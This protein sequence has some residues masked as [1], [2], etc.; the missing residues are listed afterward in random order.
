MQKLI[1]HRTLTLF[2]TIAC[3]AFAEP[4]SFRAEVAPLLVKNCLACHGPQKAEGAYR[5]DSFDRLMQ[6]GDSGEPG[7]I[8]K[9]VDS[10][11]AFRRITS[12]DVDERMPLEADPLASGQIALVRRWIEEGA[13]YDA[14]DPTLPLVKIIPPPVHPNAPSEYPATMPV[15]A[16]AFSPDGNELFVGGYYELTVWNPEDGR[17]IRRIGNIGQRTY[18]LAFSP[19]GNSL[20]VACGAPGGLGEL[21]MINP[22]DGQLQAVVASTTDVVFDAAFDPGGGR[23]AIA[24]ADGVLRVFDVV[25]REPLLEISSHSDWVTAVAW[26]LH[27]DRLATASR[28]K[29]AKVFDAKTGELIVTYNGHSG[30]VAGVAFHPDGKQV[31]TSAADKRI[32]LWK[33][34][35]GKK[36]ADVG[37]FGGELYKLTASSDFLFAVSDDKTARQYDRN[38]PKELRKYSGHSESVLSSAYHNA[39]KRLATGA[40]NG[41]VRV[42][43]T[44]DGKV[45][46]NFT[47]APGLKKPAT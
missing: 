22:A 21:R 25:T 4:V 15:T 17:L 31:F 39:S 32:H 29:T 12:E 7:F 16:L 5:V 24:A 20:A 45:I 3:T 43:N 28:D 27:G 10:S 14:K 30:A 44:E 40:L 33:I 38:T 19:D 36:S 34:K 9:D 26:N 46:V 42:W 41:E 35:D 37:S 11:E 6:E 18:A 1:V 8:A 47:A 13:R 2:F 23:I